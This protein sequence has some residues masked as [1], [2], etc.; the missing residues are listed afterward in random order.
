MVRSK[1]APMR[2]HLV[3]ILACCLPV[4]CTNAPS[5]TVD[6]AVAAVAAS[7]RTFLQELPPG[8]RAKASRPFGAEERTAWAF[9]PGVYAGVT[10]GDLDPAATERLQ[11]VLRTLLS[12][13]GLE[14][15]MAIVQL[16]NLLRELEGKGGRDVT[17]RD[18]ARYAL[19]VCGE[20]APGGAFSVRLQGHHVS[21]H[22]T[23]LD[24]WL[25]GASPHFLGSN[26][27]ERREGPGAGQ[28][29]LTAEEDLGRELLLSLD[30]AQRRTAVIAEVAPPDVLLGP[31]AAFSALGDAKGLP[32]AAMTDAQ[33]ALLW[34]LVEEFA[35]NLRL[36]FAVQELQRVR[37][38]L[39]ELRF[40]W[41][42]G[43]ERGQGHYWRVQGR[44]FAIEYDNT[45]N[46]AN[47]VHV[48]WRDLE[49]DFGQDPLR[50][51]LEQQHAAGKR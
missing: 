45:Q 43:S 18:P 42:G 9:V 35:N 2:A 51:H 3:A 50:T 33:R 7:V 6:P 31:T 29:V 40:A 24:G 47:H 8:L 10:F 22:F 23:F 5:A 15:T 39:A 16:E 38:Q 14:K 19:L 36:E 28:R 30:A 1:V 37:P 41:A 20:P 27:H 12:T 49:R 32:A 11:A 46:D 21:L 26:P 13:R 48:V 25:V 4:A 44:T 17:H 34:R